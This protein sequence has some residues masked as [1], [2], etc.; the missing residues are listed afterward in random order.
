M[1]TKKRDLTAVKN[2]VL[3]T[4]VLIHD[5]Q[6]MFQFA[7]NVVWIPIEVLEELDRF[8]SEST[9]RGANAREVHRRLGERFQSKQQ[10][11]EG[12]SLE[13]GGR[14][15]VCIHPAFNGER[16]E[17]KLRS[18]S[19]RFEIV[20]RLF[21]DLES[22]DNRILASAAY[23]ADTQANG[24]LVTKDLNMQL[25]ARALGVEAQDYRTDRVEDSDIRRTQRKS[26]QDEYDA[27]DLPGYTLQAFA[28]QERIELPEC[29]QLQPNQY[30]LLRNEEEHSHGV[31]A[32]HVRGGEFRKLR[33][34]HVTIRNGRSLTAANL[35]QRF[36][37]DA[38]YD[39]AITLVTVY[40]KAGTGKTLLSVGAALEQVQC[41]DYE[42]MLITRVIMPTGRD[43]GF[44][45]GRMEEKM[46]PWVQP[47]YDALEQLLG[48]PR[49][50]EKF[51]SKKQSARKISAADASTPHGAS[52]HKLARPYEPLMQAGL[53]EVEAIAHIRGRS[54]PRAIF[55]VDE[56]QQLTP[57]EA[58]TLVTRMGK[59][60]KIIL[61]GDLAQI[62]NPYV[63]AHT[64]GLVFTRNRLQGQPFMAH[65]N[66]FKGE[67]SEMAEVAANLM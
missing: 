45:P 46:Q 12:V 7:E 21:P 32:R 49:K 66:L 18:E 67:R 56:A 28:S 9:S 11:K 36:L 26:V 15:Q 39:P 55:I 57:H 41:G 40:G 20:R 44:L 54:I 58:K 23:V 1:A 62:D 29:R 3:D 35:G 14:L 4:N 63:D 38:L 42:K 24:V 61:I 30:V 52:Q 33:T 8:K 47:A 22:S 5:P 59:G 65:I 51:E 64:N 10:M 48:R 31:P 53:L 25:K 16:S 19:P 37:L 2:F 60:S 6:S 17:A 34:D 13:N 27:I 43:I 50:P